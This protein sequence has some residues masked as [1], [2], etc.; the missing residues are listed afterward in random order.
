MVIDKLNVVSIP[1]TP[2]KADAPPIVDANAVL[3]RSITFERFQSI[4][5]RRRKVAQLC[6][7]VQLPQFSLRHPLETSKPFDVL[8]CMELFCLFRSEGLDHDRIL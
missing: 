6:G 2:H 5:R 4:A 7:T 1:I 3:S 8:P